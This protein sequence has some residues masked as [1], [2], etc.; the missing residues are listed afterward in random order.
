MQGMASEINKMKR[1]SLLFSAFLN[2]LG[3][4]SFVGAQLLKDARNW[5]SPPDP[6]KNYNTACETYQ[7]GTGVWFFQDGVF[8]E[9]SS[10]GSVLWI[11]GKRAR[12]SLIVALWALT[13]SFLQSGFRKNYSPVCRPSSFSLYV[14]QT[15]H[16]LRDYSGHRSQVRKWIGIDGLLLFRLQG[17]RQA[18]PAWL[19]IFSSL[20]ALL[21]VRSLL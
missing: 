7:T 12:L 3:R 18:K 6:S 20:P 5:I 9:W 15:L 4:T 11:H 19:I 2:P 17:H 16:Q 21:S 10:K 13:Y 14:S 8:S 1:P